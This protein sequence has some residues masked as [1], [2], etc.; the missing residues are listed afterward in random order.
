MVCVGDPD[1]LKTNLLNVMRCVDPV[2]GPCIMSCW[3]AEYQACHLKIPSESG[4]M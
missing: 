3:T 2:C 1:G 4:R